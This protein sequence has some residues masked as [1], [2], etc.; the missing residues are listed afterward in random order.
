MKTAGSVGVNTA[1]SECGPVVRF[2]VTS[3]AVPPATGTRA[4][5]SVVP[6]KNWTVPAAPTGAT[7][8]KRNTGKPCNVA[9]DAV[10]VV[11]VTVAGGPNTVTVMGVADVL[12]L[13]NVRSPE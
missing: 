9:L 13:G 2:L 10:S 5:S 1:V 12:L 7:F 3:K 11:L 8:A 6:S 4:P